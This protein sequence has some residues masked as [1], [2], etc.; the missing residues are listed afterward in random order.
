VQADVTAIEQTTHYIKERERSKLEEFKL[1]CV[2]R[3][4]LFH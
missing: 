2:Q 4:T 1:N 3:M